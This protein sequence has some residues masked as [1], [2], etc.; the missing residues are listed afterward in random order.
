MHMTAI[1]LSFTRCGKGVR[2][3][4]LMDSASAVVQ[5]EA[6]RRGMV[7]RNGEIITET[8]LTTYIWR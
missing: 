7:M 2:W 4:L 6:L 3:Y 8:S 1:L 5:N